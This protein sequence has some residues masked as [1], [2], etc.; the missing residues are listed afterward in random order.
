MYNVFCDVCREP[1]S[2]MCAAYDV[3]RDLCADLF[4]TIFIHI[5]GILLYQFTDYCYEVTYPSYYKDMVFVK[6]GFDVSAGDSPL[7]L[8][9]GM[10]FGDVCCLCICVCHII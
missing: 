9:E 2:F 7:G 5:Y 4:W 1:F 3:C 8:C 10:F 6:N